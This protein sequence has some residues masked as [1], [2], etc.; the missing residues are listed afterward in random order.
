[1]ADTFDGAMLRSRGNRFDGSGDSFATLTNPSKGQGRKPILRW[2]FHP[3]TF[4]LL[5]MRRTG[6]R[7][8]AA[9]DLSTNRPQSLRLLGSLL[10]SL[11]YWV[12]R[13]S[14]AM[15]AESVARSYPTNCS[16]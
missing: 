1:M 5:R 7:G 11:E 2:L 9:K 3:R 8:E 4:E 12:A 6:P 15:T 14:R 16:R 13:S 10:T